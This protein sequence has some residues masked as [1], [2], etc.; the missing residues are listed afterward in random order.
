MRSSQQ[1][2]CQQGS[3]K[4]INNKYDGDGNGSGGYG[5]G[6]VA[7]LFD[8]PSGGF[9]DLHLEFLCGGELSNKTTTLDLLLSVMR[10]KCGFKNWICLKLMF[11]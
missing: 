5:C 10:L 2:F 1:E 6:L 7:F 11:D 8:G 9:M 3:H 4:K